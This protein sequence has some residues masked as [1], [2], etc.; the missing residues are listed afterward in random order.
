MSPQV[1]TELSFSFTHLDLTSSLLRPHSCSL[2]TSSVTGL[3]TIM[4]DALLASGHRWLT[5]TALIVFSTVFVQCLPPWPFF[6][7]FPAAFC[8][9]NQSRVRFREEVNTLVL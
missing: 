8:P 2:C 1:Q 7:R 4:N 3:T 9:L 5:I 6:P